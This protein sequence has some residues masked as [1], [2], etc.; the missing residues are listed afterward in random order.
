MSCLLTDPG[1]DLCS[2]STEGEPA[3]RQWPGC[4]DSLQACWL[5]PLSGDTTQPGALC[6]G[7]ASELTTGY[8]VANHPLVQ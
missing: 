1:C 7:K 3:P 4:A 5:P 8:Y 6:P 2:L